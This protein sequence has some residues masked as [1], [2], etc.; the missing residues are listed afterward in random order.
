VPDPEVAFEVD[1]TA[2]GAE[3]RFCEAAARESAV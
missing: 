1:L 3:E 2:D